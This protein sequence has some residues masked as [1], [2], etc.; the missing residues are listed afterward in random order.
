MK[1]TKREQVLL[2]VLLISLLVYGFYNFVYTKQIQKIT[3]LKASRDTY[4]Q[5]WEQAKVKIASKEKRK[6]QYESLNSKILMDTDMLFPEIEQEEVI[7]TLDKMLKDSNL[8]AGLVD[9][10]AVSSAKE[11][12]DT[13]K[14][15]ISELEKL[16]DE[17]NGTTI[18]EGSKKTDT[19]NDTL[20]VSNAYKMQATLNFKGSYD[21]L[22]SFIQKVEH[23]DKKIVI[24]NININETD[25]SD[26][27]GSIIIEFNGVPKFNDNDKFQ[28]D[29]KE[30]SGKG[31]PF[32]GSYNSLQGN[33]D[34]VANE[35]NNNETNNNDIVNNNNEAN[36]NNGV[37]NQEESLVNSKVKSDFVL[38][39]NPITSDSNTV[40]IG[41]SKDGS[42]QSYIY[43]DNEK[44][45]L[46]EFAF[47]KT[48]EE[49]FYKYKTNTKSYP[50]N[51][52]NAV[53]FIPNEGNISLDIFS[54]KR[55]SD[56]DLS[57]ANIKI[58]NET[59]KDV[60]VNILDDDKNR[61]RIE[62]IKE[63]GDILVNK[64][65]YYSGK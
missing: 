24:N 39:A 23:Y 51:F 26:I 63:I 62:I 34:I 29:F 53:K 57:G 4:S 15:S 42:K 22:I 56:S 52:N 30:P 27:E 46:V 38:R 21:E 16:V 50:E 18:K 17:F 28:W 41:R 58:T 43:S 33:K 55:V 11:A 6:E 60:V 54:Q 61:P 48:G 5:K 44:I 20:Q 37:N 32:L 64:D 7:V 9:F 8:E 65:A 25:V 49:Y 13:D 14:T 3:E 59:D 1:V 40:I 36:N 47:T 31:D 2:V 12:V 35:N 45:E 19:N 10:L